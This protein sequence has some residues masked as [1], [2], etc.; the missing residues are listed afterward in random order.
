MEYFAERVKEKSE[1]KLI[2]EICPSSQLGG[3]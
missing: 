1:G 2:V 3:E